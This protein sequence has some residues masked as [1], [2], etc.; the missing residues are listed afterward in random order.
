MSKSKFFKILIATLSFCLILGMTL[1]VTAFAAEDDVN[2]NS[3]TTPEIIAKNVE[4]GS[5]TYLYYAVPVASIPEADKVDGGFWLNVCDEDGTL[6]FRQYPEAEPVDIYGDGTVCYIFKTRGV[7]A[8]EL[9][10]V[11][12]VQVETLSG[13]K[14][15][16]ESYSVEEYLFERLYDEGF[17]IKGAEDTG[18]DGKDYIR[19]NLY[20]NL[21]KY[22]AVAQELLSPEAQDKIGDIICATA[23]A[24]TAPLGRYSEQTRI[25]LDHDEAKA[26]GKA[27]AGWKYE[28]YDYFGEIVDTGYMADGSVVEFGDSFIHFTPVYSS[29]AN[30]N[31]ITFDD[32][33]AGTVTYY[34]ETALGKVGAGSA[35][36][37]DGKWVANKTMNIGELQTAVANWNADPANASNQISKPG[38]TSV[39]T[40]VATNTKAEKFNIVEFE[41]DFSYLNNGGATL[42]YLEL[43]TGTSAN[44]TGT[45]IYGSYVQI[46]GGCLLINGEYNS[47]GKLIS[48][49]AKTPIKTDGTVYKL[50]V[51]LI[52]K[53]DGTSFLEFYAN[54]EL[55]HTTTQFSVATAPKAADF[56]LIRFRMSND[57]K[58][59]LTLDNTAMTQY[60]DE[61][62]AT[63][64]VLHDDGF[65]GDD[66]D[67]L[68]NDNLTVT[69][70]A[71]FTSLNTWEVRRDPLTGNGY[72]Y[73]NKQGVDS[74][75]SANG[76][77][78]FKYLVTDKEENAN[79]AI[80][81]FDIK[82]SG[83][84]NIIQNQFTMAHQGISGNPSSPFIPSVSGLVSDSGE[85]QHVSIT[86]R[87]LT[88][89]EAGVPI[90][91]YYEVKVGEKVVA[92]GELP[93][94]KATNF[95]INGGTYDFPKVSQIDS[96]TFAL[97]N[98]FTGEA[99]FDNFSAKLVRVEG[100]DPVLGEQL[101]EVPAT[102]EEPSITTFDEI[103]ET[104]IIRTVSGYDTFTTVEAMTD[105]DGVT[106]ENVL[107]L[108]KHTKGKNAGIKVK[109]TKT[110]GE[111][112]TLVLTFDM[113]TTSGVGGVE[114]YA[115][116]S[117]CLF[118]AS[119]F[120]T[121]N[122][123]STVT[124]IVHQTEHG[125][126]TFLYSNGV[127]KKAGYYANKTI[128]DT[129]EIELR[130]WGSATTDCY[131]D[132]IT[133]E[134]VN[135]S[136]LCG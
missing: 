60:Y 97:N 21:L 93:N 8:K 4:Y 71:N 70:N 66:F 54:G 48:A 100:Y 135:Y 10:T 31:Y 61:A 89:D 84:A 24:A 11:E 65:V 111:G 126:K 1:C 91:Y 122:K 26:P 28:L 78:A 115:A 75:S 92:K 88:V 95:K 106:R 23:P 37:V 108:N 72:L 136:D 114:F 85:Y 9:N 68:D 82:L 30:H 116:G 33:S 128:T 55:F 79:L 39:I 27:F 20:F 101:S 35:G 77:V 12:K 73:V 94:Y 103:P 25:V 124:I 14:S 104:L 123:W 129:S 62:Y 58:G 119:N 43:Y 117:G 63:D 131:F 113:L 51:R 15:I 120:I 80:F 125:I 38:S 32:G 2:E 29:E 57:P 59:T 18:E 41:S 102:S 40:Y 34:L 132:N 134:R 6:A 56:G 64:F 118:E 121:A 130:W 17:A 98:K 76:G 112:D 105:G 99:C 47:A 52:E 96:F 74:S 50:K 87:V 133:C 19:R 81:E 16:E 44:N 107:Y 127:A 36:V 83:A 22:G 110:T 90:D 69:T 49:G 42:E 67:G 5:K 53:A 109:P 86:Y 46:S 45:R 13:A 7:P 3:A